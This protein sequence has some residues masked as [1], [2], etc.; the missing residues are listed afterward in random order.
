MR[1]QAA[2]LHP[3][4]HCASRPLSP[5]ICRV[6]IEFGLWWCGGVARGVGQRRIAHTLIGGRGSRARAPR[7]SPGPGAANPMANPL[8]LPGRCS[9]PGD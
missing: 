7:R 2:P 5:R 8:A 9:R 1:P 3:R 4:Q 6:P